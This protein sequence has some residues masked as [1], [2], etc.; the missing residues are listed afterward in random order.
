MRSAKPTKRQKRE[1]EKAPAN[2]EEVW[3][4]GY[5][6]GGELTWLYLAPGAGGRI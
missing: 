3:K 2:A 5:G 6:S 1:K 4:R